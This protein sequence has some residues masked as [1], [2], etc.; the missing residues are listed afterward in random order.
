MPTVEA[1]YTAKFIFFRVSS[2][3]NPFS[4]YLEEGV[5]NRYPGIG[6][7]AYML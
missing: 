5:S 2:E 6:L 3:A 7:F 1:V 4:Y